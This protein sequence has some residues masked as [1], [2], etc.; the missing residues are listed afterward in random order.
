MK[1]PHA[2]NMLLYA[3]DAA[4]TDKPWVRWECREG[5]AGA[6][7]FDLRNHPSW[8]ASCVYRRKP[9]SVLT[10]EQIADGWVEW[11]GGKC[12]V[13]PA[14]RVIYELRNG[15]R[16]VPCKASYLSWDHSGAYDDILTYRPDPHGKF[17]QAVADGKRVEVKTRSGQ[18][19]KIVPSPAWSFIYPPDRYRIIETKTVPLGPEDAPPGSVVRPPGAYAFAWHTV[20][21]CLP[22]GIVS[23]SYGTV[24]FDALK[25]SG[26]QINCSIPLTGKWD[27]TAWEPCHKEVAV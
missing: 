4:E 24:L 9:V 12:P 2:D 16:P 20:F 22:T 11:H 26:W 25:E 27:A 21:S 13:E 15:F 23:A 18:W 1:H 5:V 10:P 6:S 17:R 8:Q 14:S 7:W 19:E 3:K